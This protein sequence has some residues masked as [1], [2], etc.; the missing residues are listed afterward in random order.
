MRVRPASLPILILAALLLA[1][2]G[3]VLL[4]SPT[5]TIEPTP[6]SVIA[7][8]DGRRALIA[9]ITPA[10]RHEYA[11]SDVRDWMRTYGADPAR[12]AAIR[13][14]LTAMPG[15]ELALVVA[16][17]HQDLWTLNESLNVWA[18]RRLQPDLAEMVTARLAAESNEDRRGYLLQHLVV[19]VQRL[20]AG[21]SRRL[22]AREQVHREALAGRGAA[23]RARAVM[24]GD[25]L[26]DERVVDICRAIMREEDPDDLVLNV[27]VRILGKH[28][29]PG[30][31]AR[32]R[33][34]A[35]RG[36]P[37]LSRLA[38]IFVLG[39][40]GHDD[41]A[42]LLDRLALDPDPAVAEA[43]RSARARLRTL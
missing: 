28:R 41:A 40:L 12:R 32:V 29:D 17:E 16:D 19:R 13:E 8:L 23:L 39:D 38:A 3:I 42:P 35:E 4:R 11:G 15:D 24:Y 26:A 7:T 31:L 20:P 18:Q 1:L 14:V 34:L 43:A 36:R 33:E 21:D 22:A 9:D 6:L 25:L 30:A 10:T 27:A 2:G 37:G 5:T